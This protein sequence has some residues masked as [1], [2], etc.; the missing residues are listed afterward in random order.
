MSNQN[1]THFRVEHKIDGNWMPN[2]YVFE[3]RE[4]AEKFGKDA[5]VDGEIGEY[6]VLPTRKPTNLPEYIKEPGD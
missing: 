2:D 1:E 4:Q 5:Q 6:R 3:N